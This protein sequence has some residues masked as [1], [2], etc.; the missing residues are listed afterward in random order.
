MKRTINLFDTEYPLVSIRVFNYNYGKYLRDCLESAVN[1]TYPNIEICFSDNCST[2]ESWEIALE[3][4]RHYPKIFSIARNASNK[5]VYGN[6]VNCAVFTRGR[7][8]L[9]LCSD[10]ALAVNFIEKCVSAFKQYPD[11]GM[12]MV[13]RNIMDESNNI[14]PEPPFYNQSCIID[15]KEQA[16]VFM[17]AAVNPSV[18]QI[19][20]DYRKYKSCVGNTPL[21]LSGRWYAMRIAD[22]TMSCNFPMGYIKEPLL[23]HRIHAMNDSIGAAKDLIEIVGPYVLHRQFTEIARPAKATKAIERLPAATEKLSQLCLRYS[24][25]S[26][27]WDEPELASRYL[28]LSVAVWTGIQNNPDFKDLHDYMLAGEDEKDIIYQRLKEKSNFETRNV[29]Y[30]PPPGSI[31]LHL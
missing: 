2:D 6:I 5:G 25:K 20:Y 17:M 19:L 21:T 23:K 15:G 30:D 1:Q 29:S 12:V 16:A 4:Q 10:D 31:S 22:F 9:H 28:H 14:T 26:I 11:C 8:M 7:Y 3:Y 13:N 27:I 24:I 18:S